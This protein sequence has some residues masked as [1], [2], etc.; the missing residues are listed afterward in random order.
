MLPEMC[1]Y[2][3]LLLLPTASELLVKVN[4]PEALLTTKFVV[5]NALDYWRE[6]QET[7]T[8][9][10]AYQMQGDTEGSICEPLFLSFRTNC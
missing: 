2:R 7:K 3:D 9:G 8:Q 10:I 6:I 4:N 1:I 5:T